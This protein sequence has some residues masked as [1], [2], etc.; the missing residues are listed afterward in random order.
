MYFMNNY[1]VYDLRNYFNISYSSHAFEVE[2]KDKKSICREG[3]M[4]RVMVKGGES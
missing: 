4:T 2:F 1:H 3:L